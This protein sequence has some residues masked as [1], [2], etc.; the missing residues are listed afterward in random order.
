MWPDNWRELA[1]KGPD[2]TVDQKRLSRLSRYTSPNAAIDALIGVQ[3][4]ISAGEFKSNTPFPDKGTPEQQA[5]WRAD[6]GIPEAP[7]KYD[8]KIAEGHVWGENDVP[9]INDF[10]AHAHAKNVPAPAVKAALE[11][12]NQLQEKEVA[13]RADLDKQFARDASDALRQEWGQEYR[14][15]VNKITAMLGDTADAIFQARGADG[16]V[17]G[18]NPAVLRALANLALEINPAVTLVPGAGANIASAVEDE[19]AQLNKLMA[20]RNSDYWKGPEA[21]KKQERYRQL[22]E[23]KEKL[24]GKSAAA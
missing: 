10:L 2:G 22:L 14:A 20:D 12:Y 19:L 5:Q 16:V 6:N 7:D 18:S 4:K 9:I 11:W 24:A 8:T 3:N 21:A 13:A 17:L 15:N 1:A 23:A